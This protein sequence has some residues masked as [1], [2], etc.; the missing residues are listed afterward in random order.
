MDQG[1]MIY[2]RKERGSAKKMLEK[3][4]SHA[5]TQTPEPNYQYFK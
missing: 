5:Q 2:N 3:T 4:L 1:T